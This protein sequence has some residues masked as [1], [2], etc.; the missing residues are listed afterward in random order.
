MAPASPVA[1]RTLYA[2][3]E[4]S[5]AETDPGQRIAAEAAAADPSAAL[6]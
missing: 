2:E 5:I 1:A 6:A 3:I 4:R